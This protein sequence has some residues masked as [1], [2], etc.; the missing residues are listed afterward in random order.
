M[1]GEHSTL[2]SWRAWACLHLAEIT[3][4]KSDYPRDFSQLDQEG[5]KIPTLSLVEK[6]L[7]S[8]DSSGLSEA[9]ALARTTPNTRS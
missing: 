1:S 8:C 7:P 4:P 3:L 6:N 2:R 9:E 5:L